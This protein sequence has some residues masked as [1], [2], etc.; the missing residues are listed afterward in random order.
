MYTCLCVYTCVC[1]YKHITLSP[2]QRVLY[3]ECSADRNSVCV[4]VCVCVCVSNVI[5]HS[6]LPFSPTTIIKVRAL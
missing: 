6:C 3:K 5:M 1:V 4:C 2:A